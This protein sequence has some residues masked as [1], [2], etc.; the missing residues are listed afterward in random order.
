LKGL[1]IFA[2]LY[3]KLWCDNIS[4]GYLTANQCLRHIPSTLI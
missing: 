4:T 2:P 1:S 3:A